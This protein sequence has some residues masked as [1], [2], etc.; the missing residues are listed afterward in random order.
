[1]AWQV[2]G[3]DILESR[4]LANLFMPWHLGTCSIYA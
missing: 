4:A 3:M 2:G 1:M